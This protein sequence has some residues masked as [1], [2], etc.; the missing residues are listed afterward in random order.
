MT[1]LYDYPVELANDYF[2]K[3]NVLLNKIGHRYQYK[4]LTFLEKVTDRLKTS[5]KLI[6]IDWNNQQEST[7]INT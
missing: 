3:F 5:A 6:I 4:K 2:S 1:V 7:L